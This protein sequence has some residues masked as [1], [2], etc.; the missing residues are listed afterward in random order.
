MRYFRIEH[1]GDNTDPE[2]V[3][4]SNHVEDIGLYCVKIAYGKHVGNNFPDDARIYL[5]KSKKGRRLDSLLSN[6]IN[7]LIVN[8]AMKDTILQHGNF[9]DIEIETLPFTLFDPSGKVMSKDYW[10][11]NPIGTKDVLNKKFSDIHYLDAPGDPDHGKVVSVRKFVINP[12]KL[13]EKI[14]IFRVP[15]AK[16]E[17]FINETLARAFYEKGYTNVMLEEIE[18]ETNSRE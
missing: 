15:E 8:T 3:I 18:L 16:E 9:P 12:D 4:I 1:L 14:A 6:T 17:T 10:I 11:I 5:E 2:R 7:Y 13:D